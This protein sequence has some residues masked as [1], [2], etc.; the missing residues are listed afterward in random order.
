MLTLELAENTTG[1]NVNAPMVD[2]LLI[3]QLMQ[4]HLIAN[5][6]MMKSKRF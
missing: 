6:A 1:M 3:R 4:N 2:I 5:L